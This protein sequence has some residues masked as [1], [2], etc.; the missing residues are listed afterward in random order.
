MTRGSIAANLW[1][2]KRKISATYPDC[3]KDKKIS[4]FNQD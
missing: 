3:V 1:K 2:R 4:L